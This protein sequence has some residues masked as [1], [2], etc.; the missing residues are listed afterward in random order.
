DGV[1]K[2]FQEGMGRRG[3]DLRDAWF[4]KFSEYQAQYPEQAS[5]LQAM[6]QRELPAGWDKEL[7]SYPAD[8]KGKA[9]R[10]ASAE[11]LNKIAPYVPWLL[12]GSADLTPSTQ[13]RMTF[14][15]NGKQE[16]AGDRLA[17]NYAG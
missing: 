7:T 1:Y 4:A 5:H 10:I 12:G 13:T 8:A 14:E 3:H 11:V 2:H 9:G 17:D 6:Q 15:Q 16:A